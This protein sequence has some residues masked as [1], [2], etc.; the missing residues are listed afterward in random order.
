MM[1][2]Y[3]HLDPDT[4]KATVERLAYRKDGV[5]ATNSATQAGESRVGTR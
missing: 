5:S 4:I 1:Q 3:A 2:R